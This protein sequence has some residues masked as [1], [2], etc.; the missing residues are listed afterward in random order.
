ILLILAAHL[1]GQSQTRLPP[2]VPWAFEWKDGSGNIRDRQAFEEILRTESPVNFAGAYLKGAPL[3]WVPAPG[4]NFSNADLTEARMNNMNLVRATL[5][6]TVLTKAN[7]TGTDLSHASLIFG[8]MIEVT[9]S[10]ANLTGA[11]LSFANLAQSNFLYANLQD[12]DL[13]NARLDET[14]MTMARLFQANFSHA[15]VLGTNLSLSNLQRAN[16][17]EANLSSSELRDADLSEANLSGADLGGAKLDGAN[18]ERTVF[19]PQALPELRG[20]AAAKNL[21]F[22]TYGRNPDS[23]V[24]L[25]KQFEEGGFREQERKITYA[26]KRREAELASTGWKWFNKVLFDWTCQYGMSPA[27]PLVL[28]FWLWLSCSLIY[29][30]CFQTAGRAGLYLVRDKRIYDDDT[31]KAPSPKRIAVQRPAQ[32]R[33]VP[34]VLRWLC[35]ELALFCIAMFFS[36]MS[37][38]NIGFRELNFGR[39]LRLLPPRRFDIKPEGWP[40]IVAGL[41]SLISVYLI[42]LWVLAYFGR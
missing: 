22:L 15:L 27:R 37:A 24:Q 34:W 39:W 7:L 20:I 30:F 3:S 10:E 4:A 23:L 12:A 14:S 25:R 2:D 5:D 40:R 17:R 16:F 41:Q 6:R 9:F 11:N 38:F 26:I 29:F 31:S 32:C 42:A 33:F 13:T 19:E 1:M 8:T 18:V 36:L 21:E 35:H 28:G